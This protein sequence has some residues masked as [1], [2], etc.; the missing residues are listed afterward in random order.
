MRTIIFCLFTLFCTCGHA[1]DTAQ[2]APETPTDDHAQVRAVVQDY[3]DGTSFNRPELLESSFDPEISMYFTRN[4]ANWMPARE[5]YIGFF[6]GK[7]VG[8]PTG[9]QGSIRL[10]EV[11]GDVATAKAE[12]LIPA[13]KWLFIDYFLLKKIDNRWRI[14]SKTA[15]SGPTDQHGGRILMAV[16]NATTYGDSDLPTANHFGEIA[17][18]Y[19]VFIEAGYTV[20]FVSPEGG[21]TEVD[22]LSSV[23]SITAP[24]LRDAEF[25]YRVG[26]T[27]RAVDLKAADYQAIYFPGGGAA[28]FGVADN[29]EIQRL[30]RDIYESDGAVAAVC[31]GTAG[32]TN[33]RLSDGRGFLEGKQLTGFPD[34]LERQTAPYYKTFE[35]SIDERVAAQGGI[36]K[37][38]AEMSTGFYVADGR[39]VTGMDHSATVKVAKE[40]VRVLEER[41]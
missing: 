9:R 28:M 1:Q 21:S 38:G 17:A 20:D 13:K 34:A 33:T 32:I 7:E 4:D 11:A 19:D 23:D 22:Y 15:S 31:H 26:H 14:V 24:Y 25:W 10:I 2:P 35:F 3:I 18:A 41:Q 36:F 6:R 8:S 16:S 37:A 12:I 39:L 5:E 40:V 27:R 30:I 29:R